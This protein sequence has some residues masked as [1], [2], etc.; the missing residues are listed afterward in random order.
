[1]KT[2]LFTLALMLVS[3]HGLAQPETLANAQVVDRSSA[4]NPAK[5][6]KEAEGNWLAFRIPA[7]EGTRSPCCWQGNW[8]SMEE[9]GCRLDQQ[10]HNY[11]TRTS[12]PLAEHVIV[13]S[14]IENTRVD[15]MRILGESCPVDAG[16]ATVVWM[17]E[18]KEKAGIDWLLNAAVTE[19]EHSAL[20][21]LALHGASEA[22]EALYDLAIEDQ[23]ELSENAIFWLG[24]SRAE[25]G[26]TLLEKLLA[27][28]PQGDTRR[29]IN[30]ALSQNDSEE[31]AG[32]LM[33]VSRTDD[34][35]KQRADAL[36]WL[37]QSYPDQAQ[38]W[39]MEILASDQADEISER[40]VFAVS[41]LPGEKADEM[42]L[43][44]AM[45][46]HYSRTI[47]RQAI[48]WL[49]QSDNDESIARLSGLLSGEK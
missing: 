8:K 16:G 12:S 42:L 6:V 18:V 10:H 30:F 20:H 38:P 9:P 11:G 23:H 47:R 3:S 17:D 31:A 33:E 27:K 28:L 44:L 7:I 4:N 22:G 15:D 32:L 37:A 39:L 49:A 41:Q 1:M 35:E 2:S 48:F 25:Q 19:Q 40:A 46:S 45:D 24:N 36:F 14:R 5:L 29:H 43:K 13:Y 26:F 21:G 34:D